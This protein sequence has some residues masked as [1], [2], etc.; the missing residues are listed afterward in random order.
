MAAAIEF[1]REVS[2]VRGKN[3]KSLFLTTPYEAYLVY[4]SILCYFLPMTITQ[5]DYN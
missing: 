2:V 4:F 3:L 1:V 5:T